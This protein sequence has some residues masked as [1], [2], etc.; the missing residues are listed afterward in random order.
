MSKSGLDVSELNDFVKHMITTIENDFPKQAKAFMRSEAG[1]LNTHAKRTAR[2]KVNKKTGNY[3]N[4][5]KKGKKVYEY[6]DDK[7]NIMVS[8][9]SPH[10]HLIEYGHK[11]QNGA[12]IPGKFVLKTAAETFEPIFS[13]DLENKLIDYLVK[14]IERS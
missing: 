5:F 11:T 8:N 13:E 14:G 9:T 7:Y 6:K 4:G 12:F 3:I 1:K 10:A 2:K